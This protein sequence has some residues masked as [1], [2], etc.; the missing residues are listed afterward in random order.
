[1]QDDVMSSMLQTV[2]VETGDLG[3]AGRVAVAR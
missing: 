2:M 1:M 3:G